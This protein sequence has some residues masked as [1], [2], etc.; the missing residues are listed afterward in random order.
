MHLVGNADRANF[1]F[2]KKEIYC[3]ATGWP[4]SIPATIASDPVLQIRD[5]ENEFSFQIRE[6]KPKQRFSAFRIQ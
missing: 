5:G 6:K 3:A 2:I 4:V 1:I